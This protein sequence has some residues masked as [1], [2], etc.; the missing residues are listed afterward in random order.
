MG[1]STLFLGSMKARGSRSAYV[2]VSPDISFGLI[3][4][5]DGFLGLDVFFGLDVFLGLVELLMLEFL[6]SWGDLR[7]EFVCKFLCFPS[8]IEDVGDLGEDEGEDWL[9]L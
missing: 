7:M 2:T 9:E 4:G 6:D 8:G 5:L 1:G 3:L